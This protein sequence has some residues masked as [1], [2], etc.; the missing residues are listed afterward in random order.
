MY[1]HPIR[2]L[3][4]FC[5][6]FMV[7]F[8]SVLAD[9]IMME[10]P[11]SPA[12]KEI[13]NIFDLLARHEEDGALEKLAQILET[14]IDLNSLKD[15][16]HLGGCSPM[17][18]AVF[19]THA[20]P[21]LNKY[22]DI[23]KNRYDHVLLLLQH[24]ADV[25]EKCTGRQ[26]ETPLHFAA[27]KGDINLINL[28]VKNGAD[29]NARDANGFT[30][31]FAVFTGT[32][33]AA[34][35]LLHLGADVTINTGN[36]TIL[37]M[38]VYF[39]N[40]EIMEVLLQH[41]ADPR[42]G[43][44]SRSP[45]QTAQERLKDQGLDY[46]LKK[47]VA[48]MEEVVIKR[49]DFIK[50]HPGAP[51]VFAPPPIPVDQILPEKVETP[52]VKAVKSN[53]IEQIKALLAETNDVNSVSPQ[54]DMPLHIAVKAGSLE[55]A[56]LLLDKGAKAAI[57][58]ADG[59]SPLCL[60]RQN[61]DMTRLLLSYDV[62]PNQPG[63][64]GQTALQGSQ[65]TQVIALLLKAGADINH[66]SDYGY[67]ALQMAVDNNDVPIAEFLLTQGADSNIQTDEGEAPLHKAAKNQNEDMVAL[68][69]R[70]GANPQLKNIQ[71]FTPYDIASALNNTA[72]MTSLSQQGGQRGDIGRLLSD[73][74][75][76]SNVLFVE[77]LLN[78]GGDPNTDAD[79]N[80]PLLQQ[81]VRVYP[82][83]KAMILLLIKHGAQVTILDANKNSLL[84]LIVD[85]EI[86]NILIQKGVAV[87]ALNDRHTA[88]LHVWADRGKADAVGVL[89]TNGAL[90]D[91]RNEQ[92]LTPLE[93]AL[94][95]PK[96]QRP[97]DGPPPDFAGETPQYLNV[98]RLLLEAGA[99]TTGLLTA[100]FSQAP[101]YY[102]QDTVNE[103]YTV[104]R[105]QALALIQQAEISRL[106][107]NGLR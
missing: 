73:A 18:N 3:S 21:N 84:H 64:Y 50:N 12:I 105:K 17:A 60:A 76:R 36:G 98:I 25:K 15:E 90:P 48:L 4:V 5:V 107:R 99:D 23:R 96:D 47:C 89:L 71:G 40:P 8:N 11:P 95:G 58:N 39:R 91:R 61:P 82:Q 88:P 70:Y 65:N 80:W 79:K 37:D 54:G 31:L 2:V 24:G 102:R 51:L 69:L 57:Q 22:T 104:F 53:D 33:Q 81:A 41:G 63:V 7:H 85:P 97:A 86:M 49:E 9:R 59:E 29:V 45:L 75:E 78:E 6:C 34:N 44:R 13:N 19:F 35:L 43:Q 27:S 74:V 72:L 38:A 106:K 94:Q 42:A 55:A 103:G 92:G 10:Q 87:D 56:Q 32:P 101:Y 67:N 52:L 100:D 77:K 62:L 14:G 26:G 83:N 93:L 16:T 30:P 66:R 1:R 20:N 46:K 68:L 28:L